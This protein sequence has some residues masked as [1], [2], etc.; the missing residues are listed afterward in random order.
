MSSGGIEFEIHNNLKSSS[1]GQTHQHA[2]IKNPD[3]RSHANKTQEQSIVIRIA[4]R[5]KYSFIVIAL[6]VMVCGRYV[7]L[8]PLIFQQV[9]NV[10]CAEAKSTSCVADEV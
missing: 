8:E 5:I 3:H 1:L 9:A 7:E 4:Y 6:V 10:L 2:T